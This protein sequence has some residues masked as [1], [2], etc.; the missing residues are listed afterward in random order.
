M[1]FKQCKTEL[2]CDTTIRFAENDR[3][4]RVSRIHLTKALVSTSSSDRKI[5]PI[6][7]TVAGDACAKSL[8]SNTKLTLSVNLILSPLG[9]VS[10]WLSSYIYIYI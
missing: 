9:I 4:R 7:D 2:R 10:R 3:I 8:V 5:M 1:F 6:L